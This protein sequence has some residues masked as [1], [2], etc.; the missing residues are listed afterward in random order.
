M[1]PYASVVV[2]TYNRP[3]ALAAC[4]AALVA[5]EAPTGGF[6]VVVVDDGGDRPLDAVVAPFGDR[7][8]L[9]RQTNAGPAAARNAGAAAA[10]GAVLAFTDDD[11]R[12]APD[13]LARVT[14]PL[15]GA[16]DVLV[17]GRTVNALADNAYAEASQL[18]VDYLTERGGADPDFVASN[19]IAATAAA[20]RAVGGFAEHY[21]LAAGEDRDVCDR[22]RASGRPI[23][24]ASDALV[25]HYHRLTLRSFW[26]QHRNYGRGARHVH[27]DR[28]RRDAEAGR[29][30]APAFYLDL[31][32]YPLQRGR[33]G[34]AW[35][36]AGLMAVSQAAT[37]VGYVAEGRST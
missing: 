17:G 14:A 37:A 18:L 12:P 29:F 32:R 3:D 25:Y 35:A 2:P 33:G 11:C 1:T 36:L 31:I 27:R 5:Q 16:P 30:A 8:R 6:E 28:G 4:L 26:R 21:P 15:G 22:W 24:R 20:F 7:V 9:V 19:N 23:R 34:R 10:H 13:W